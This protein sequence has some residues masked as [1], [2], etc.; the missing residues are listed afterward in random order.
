MPVDKVKHTFI[1]LTKDGQIPMST[2]FCE[3]YKSPFSAQYVY[4]CNKLITTNMVY[5]NITAISNDS[6]SA[7]IFV[8][9][10]SLVTDLYGMKPTDNS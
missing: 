2:T 7:Q 9:T 3:H 4:R 6:T 10:I 5:S 1:A 8:G